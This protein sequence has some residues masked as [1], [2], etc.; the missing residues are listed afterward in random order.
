MKPA[1]NAVL[2]Q[3]LK[4][5]NLTLADIKETLLNAEITAEEI[6]DMYL[7]LNGVVQPLVEADPTLTTGKLI[8][9]ILFLLMAELTITTSDDKLLDDLIVEAQVKEA[10]ATEPRP[11]A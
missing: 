7:K 1:T 5:E 3:M 4:L 6:K 11:D 10:S 9:G 2:R 8:G